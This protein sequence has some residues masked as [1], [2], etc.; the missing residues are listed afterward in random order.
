MYAE[1]AVAYS[2]VVRLSRRES[3][4][5]GR[6]NGARHFSS[7]AASRPASSSVRGFKEIMKEIE[8]TRPGA[9]HAGSQL[10]E[11]IGSGEISPIAAKGA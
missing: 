3:H 7:S 9:R 4:T 6:R 5:S 1:V 10:V 11:C 8:T 2:L